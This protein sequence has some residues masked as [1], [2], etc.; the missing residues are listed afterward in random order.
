MP[1]VVVCPSCDLVH[2]A[3][4]S[5]ALSRT[6]CSRCRA[7]LH[8]VEA[9]SLDHAIALA[10]SALV[11]YALANAY[12]LVEIH[13]SGATRVTT[14]AGAALGLARNGF[15]ALGLLVLMTTCLA[16]L[17]QLLSLLYLLMPL[18]HRRRARHQRTVFRFLT[19]VRDWTFFEVFLLGVLVALVRLT[20]YA[21]VIPGISLVCCGVLM[22]MLAALT[23]RTTPQQFWH[24]VQSSHR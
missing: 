15:P 6:R 14:L 23:N 20:S 7:T 3:E 1:R 13:M 12:P 18:R 2:R 16:P 10:V 22:L 21:K 4:A 11:V 8:D 5:P 19:T 24:W 17:L 9:G